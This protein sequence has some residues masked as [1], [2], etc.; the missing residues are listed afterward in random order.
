MVCVRPSLP[1]PHYA[2]RCDSLQMETKSPSLLRPLLA[3]FFLGSTV[4]LRADA[5]SEFASFSIFGKPDLAQLAQG[6]AKAIR[7][8]QMSTPR[9][10]SVQSCWVAPGSPA[11][12]ADKLRRWNPAGHQEL[13][14]YLHV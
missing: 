4:S 11:Q 5:V 1:A 13:K 14:V 8:E 12:N 3:I 10:L 7:G 6:D 9:F 2:N